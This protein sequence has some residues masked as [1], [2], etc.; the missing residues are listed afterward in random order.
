MHRIKQR[1]D[2]MLELLKRLERK[3]LYLIARV[4]VLLLFGSILFFPV[5]LR[6]MLAT[7]VL[8]GAILFANIILA[9]ILLSFALQR[10]AR[11]AAINNFFSLLGYDSA[12][13]A[14]APHVL[15]AF[16]P[17]DALNLVV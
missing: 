1:T 7:P 16:R 4:I 13:L 3:G 8:L 11:P 15:I 2:K 12:F 17:R 9:I 14:L 6:I 5:E 10:I